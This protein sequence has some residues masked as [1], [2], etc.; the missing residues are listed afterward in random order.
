MIGLCW[1]MGLRRVPRSAFRVPR[2]LALLALLPSAAGAVSLEADKTRTLEAEGALP[3]AA[4]GDPAP[5]VP[6]LGD[7]GWQAREKAMRDLIEIGAPARNALRLA[8]GSSDPEVRWRAQYA[9]SQIDIGFDLLTTD[10]GRK[11]YASAA[12]TRAKK[13]GQGAAR[14]LYQEV[15]EKFP[16]TRWAAAARERLGGTR[17]AEPPKVSEEALANLVAKLGSTAWSERQG[18]SV[19]LAALGASARRALETAT[20]SPDPEVAWRARKLLDRLPS[21]EAAAPKGTGDT[22]PKVRLEVGDPNPDPEHPG[23][24]AANLDSLV[25]TLASDEPTEVAGAREVIQN[26]GPDAIDPLVRALDG[27][28]E[29]TGV[30]I[31]DLL[32]KITRQKLGFEPERWRA[33][34]KARRQKE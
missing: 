1:N 3:A 26:L 11:L 7:P 19:R 22:L 30:E 20:K 12:E 4:K 21:D 13:A 25:K 23:A 5:L 9:L 10:P 31:M 29:V 34:W 2:W 24:K 6:K 33:W 16:D 18:A 27:A 14:L 15:T 8:L 28:N 17:P 32:Q